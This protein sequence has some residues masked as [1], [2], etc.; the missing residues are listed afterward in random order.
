VTI[1]IILNIIGFVLLA[2]GFSRGNLMALIVG[3]I[4]LSE[5]MLMFLYFGPATEA[6]RSLL[7]PK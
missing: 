1:A 2:V 4:M 3:G 6:A 7:F 5:A